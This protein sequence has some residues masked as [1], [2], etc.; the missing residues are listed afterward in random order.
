MKKNSWLVDLLD[1]VIESI[2]HTFDMERWEC[3]CEKKDNYEWAF[4]ERTNDA[5]NSRVIYV[6][7]KANT[8]GYKLC[9]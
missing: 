8:L 5:N 1:V 2:V 3:V 6:I 4:D 9:V 7:C